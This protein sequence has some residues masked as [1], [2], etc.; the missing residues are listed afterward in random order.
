MSPDTFVLTNCLGTNVLCDIA[1]QVG[2]DRFVHVSTDEVYGSRAEG[3]FSETDILT[4]SSPYSASKAGS[5]LIA[6]GYHTSFGLPVSVTRA[7]NNYGAFQY[8]EKVIPLFIT[9]LLD[10]RSVPVYGDGSNIRDWLYVDDHCAAIE[11]VRTGGEPG[12]VYNIGGSAELTNLD[13]TRRLIELVG[14]DD[15]LIEYVEDRLGHDFRYSITIDQVAA[16]GYT[17]SVTIDQGLE[18]TV[19]WYRDNEWW[20]RPRK[21]SAG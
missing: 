19:A 3:S 17:P 21:E 7:S 10:G 4:P 1:R 9:N 14:V 11:L 8:P 5:D 2:V 16:L 12:E 20:W 18:R 13:L 15:S 6:L